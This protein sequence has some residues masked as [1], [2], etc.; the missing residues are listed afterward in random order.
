VADAETLEKLEKLDERPILISVA[1]YLGKTRLIDNVVLNNV[2][3][4]D[5]IP[6][7]V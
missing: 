3:K 5:V 1:A 7:K 2:K 4:K 6:A